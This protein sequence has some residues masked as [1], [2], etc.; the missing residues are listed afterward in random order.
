LTDGG[1]G[2]RFKAAEAKSSKGR[3]DPTGGYA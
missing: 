2:G 1:V 3:K